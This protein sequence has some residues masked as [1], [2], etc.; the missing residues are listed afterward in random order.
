MVLPYQNDV[1]LALVRLS[2]KNSFEPRPS[3]KILVQSILVIPLRASLGIKDF[4]NLS[5]LQCFIFKFLLFFNNLK[6]DLRCSVDNVFKSFVLRHLVIV[7]SATPRNCPR[8][9]SYYFICMQ[10]HNFRPK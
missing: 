5:P 2:G 9:S 1:F 8:R 4:I 6:S 3:D 10:N 7:T